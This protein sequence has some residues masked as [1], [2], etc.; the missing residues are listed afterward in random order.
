MKYKLKK[1]SGDASFREFY[2]LKKNNSS[3]IIVNAKKDKYKNLIVYTVINNILNS[4]KIIAPKLLSNHIK[5]NMIEI[6]DL[7][8]KSF[9][10][11]VVRKKNKLSD[12]KSLINLLIKIQKIKTKSQYKLGKNKVKI[13]KYSISNLHK[14]SDLFFDWYLKYT[15]KKKNTSKIKKILR[16]ELNKIYK[17][18]KY[19]NDTFVHRDFHVSNIMYHKKKLGVIDSQDALIG[20]PLYDVASLIDDVRIKLHPALQNKLFNYYFK[21]SKLKKENIQNLKNDFD[22][23]SVQRNLKILGIFVR[24]HKRDGKSNYL[25]YLPYTWSLINRRLK[26]SVFKDFNISINKILPINDFKNLKK[27]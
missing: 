7:G 16:V 26:N 20:N 4:H 10:D 12:Y 23:L 9:Y 5:N 11:Y 1:I 15:M 18:L 2:R 3:S 8:E 21:T 22:I 13:F 19:K 27:I 24:L 14:E 25:K 17:K 6:S